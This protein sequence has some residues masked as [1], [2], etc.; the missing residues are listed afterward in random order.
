MKHSLFT[1][2]SCFSLCLTVDAINVSKDVD[3]FDKPC[4]LLLSDRTKQ[5]AYRKR[6][7]VLW[8]LIDWFSPVN[9]DTLADIFINNRPIFKEP[10]VNS[11]TVY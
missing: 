10:K 11:L 1:A 6:S 9:V 8:W 7:I 3:N 2:Y 4:E 5:I